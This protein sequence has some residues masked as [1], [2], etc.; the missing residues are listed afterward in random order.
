MLLLGDL[1]QV[2]LQDFLCQ[3]LLEKLVMGGFLTFLQAVQ[4]FLSGG[5][6][7]KPWSSRPTC[8]ATSTLTP[9]LLLR[10]GTVLEKVTPTT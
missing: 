5:L 6:V 7:P 9:S 8:V 1:D 10:P 2:T 4:F 3:D